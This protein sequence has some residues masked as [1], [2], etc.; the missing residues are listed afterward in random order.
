MNIE[1]RMPS[2]LIKIAVLSAAASAIQILES[3]LP[4]FLPWMKPGLSNSLLLFSLIEFSSGFA[5]SL[6]ILRTVLT[7]F[8]LGMIFS[9]TFFL[10]LAGGVSSWLLMSLMLKYKKANFGIIGIS[11]AG[12]IANNL[13]QFAV[14]H[15][16]LPGKIQ[17]FIHICLGIWVG[18]PAGIAVAF[19]TYELLR[20]NTNG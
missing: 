12:A 18:I 13:A 8:F 3:P 14:L 20:R 2:L 4:R 19:I 7:A 9:P 11:I 5:F 1:S 10:S 16:I 6:V 17:N 15:L